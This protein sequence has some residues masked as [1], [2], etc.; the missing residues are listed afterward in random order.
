MRKMILI[1]ALFIF[2]I[3]P[4]NGK[5]QGETHLSLLSVD[6]WPEYDQP[7]VLVIY[8][9]TLAPGTSLPANLAIRI[10]V[11]TQINAV[12]VKDSAGG[13]INSP[14]ENTLQGKWSVL[15]MTTNSLQVQVE[16]YEPL[17]KDGNTRHIKFEWAGDYPVDRLDANF[18][19]PLGAEDI[20]MNL[21]PTDTSPG[22]DG[23]TNYHIQTVNLTAGQSFLLTIDYKR[24]TDDLSN[25]G[26]PVQAASTPGPDTPGRISMTGILPWVL[27]GIGILLIVSGVVAFFVWQRGSQG[28]SKS[29]KPARKLGENEDGFTYCHQCGKRAQ[30]GD[31]FCRTCGT[32]LKRG[33]T[34]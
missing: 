30:P 15:K 23:L 12:A 25:S 2:L 14:Y 27:A 32:R 26:Q 13:L 11:G 6:I 1:L 28:S 5:A 7:A 22:Q 16:F 3:T 4:A 18:L 29:K 8:R 33:S 10:P 19:Q 31:I 21:T 17:V 24:Q 20:S 34:E 9:I